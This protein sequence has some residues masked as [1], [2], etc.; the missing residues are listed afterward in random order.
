MS[1]Q[2]IADMKYKALTTLARQDGIRATG[3]E[4]VK[5]DGIPKI[6][7]KH[8]DTGEDVVSLDTQQAG[9]Y[10]VLTGSQSE[11]LAVY[12]VIPRFGPA[13]GVRDEHG[14][15][16]YVVDSLSF[17]VKRIKRI[18]KGLVTA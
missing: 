15:V 9:K 3:A 17:G 8:L 11:V 16:N 18:P 10:I 2:H 1:E 7:G 4:F 12:K 6:I 13:R 5:F 14:N